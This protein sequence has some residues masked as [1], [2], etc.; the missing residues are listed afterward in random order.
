MGYKLFPLRIEFLEF[1]ET[2]FHDRQLFTRG[3]EKWNSIQLQP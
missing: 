1:A 2:R 3:G